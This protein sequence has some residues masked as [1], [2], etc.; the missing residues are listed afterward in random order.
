MN[1]I[2]KINYNGGSQPDSI[3]DT[4]SDDLI[5]NQP[6][7]KYPDEEI[8]FIK[9]GIQIFENINKPSFIFDGRNILNPDEI[10]KLGFKYISL[11]RK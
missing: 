9:Q 3:I 5:T 6:Y 10:K 1:N 2:Y 4:K 8:D 7:S 11:G